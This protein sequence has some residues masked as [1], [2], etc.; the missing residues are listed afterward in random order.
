MPSEPEKKPEP[1]SVELD[2]DSERIRVLGAS[3]PLACQ[4]KESDAPS[5]PDP[6][7]EAEEEPEP[8][9]VELEGDSERVR[10]LGAN[11]P[12]GKSLKLLLACVLPATVSTPASIETASNLFFMRHLLL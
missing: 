1:I 2:G 4:G 11:R 6:R 8:I 3:R 10:V 12:L 9:S 7:V 5:E